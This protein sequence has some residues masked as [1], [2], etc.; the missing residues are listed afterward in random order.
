MG[1]WCLAGPP[2]P[3]NVKHAPNCGHRFV[4]PLKTPPPNLFWDLDFRCRKPPF[5]GS[6]DVYYFLWISSVELT[7][8]TPTEKWGGSKRDA[9]WCSPQIDSMFVFSLI[10]ETNKPTQNPEIPKNQLGV[11]TNFCPHPCEI[12]KAP[13]QIFQSRTCL[14]MN[15]FILNG[16]FRASWFPKSS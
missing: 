12:V 16:F 13:N 11:R 5:V 1:F 4:S 14:Q 7:A 8:E 9:K 15:S 10:L 2:G 3:G 6:S